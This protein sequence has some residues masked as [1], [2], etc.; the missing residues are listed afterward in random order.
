MP[1]PITEWDRSDLEVLIKARVEESLTLDYKQSASLKDND[2]GKK[3]IAKDVSAFANSNGGRLIYGIIE[4]DNMP[5]SIDS[6]VNETRFSREWLENV[7]TSNISPRIGG[8]IIKPVSLAPGQCVYIIEVPA[9]N[10][11]G[12]HQASDKRYYKRFNFKS[13]PMEDYEVRDVMRRSTTPLLYPRAAIGH[14]REIPDDGRMIINIQFV[15]ENRSLQ[16]AMY[17]VMRVFVHDSSPFSCTPGWIKKENSIL[18]AGEMSL[19]VEGAEQVLMA[20]RDLPLFKEELFYPGNIHIEMP[21][22]VQHTLIAISINTPGMS[23]T[24]Y[25][26]LARGYG[27]ATLKER[28]FVPPA[29]RLT[30]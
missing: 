19:N 24:R 30:G 5:L 25:W 9:A 17:V 15:I 27:R 3:E 10:V 4:K 23:I 7:I 20:P 1:K 14:V 28:F 8:V 26:D 16:P 29:V 11:D 6:G 21:A 22:V 18:V 2:N 12:P 13:V